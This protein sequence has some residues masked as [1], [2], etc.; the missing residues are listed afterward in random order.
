MRSSV[1]VPNFGDV[2]VGG[3]TTPEAAADVVGPC[4]EA[5][6]PRP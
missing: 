6:P 1:N 5:G 3:L 2:V 4:A